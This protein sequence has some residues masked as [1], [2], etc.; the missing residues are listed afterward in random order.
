MTA[1]PQSPGAPAERTDAP[2]GQFMFF[3]F[4]AAVL[5]VT[6]AIALLTIVQSYW[7]L[8]AVFGFHVLV[9]T[10][11]GLVIARGLTDKTKFGRVE[12]RK[13]R[14]AGASSGRRSRAD[15]DQAHL[16]AI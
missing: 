15:L 5:T 4:T 6:L 13:L 11:V 16:R 10:V 3:V 2:Y 8:A 9:T 7:M 14:S 1:Q 12:V